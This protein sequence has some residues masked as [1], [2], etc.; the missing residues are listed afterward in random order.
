MQTLSKRQVGIFCLALILVLFSLAVPLRCVALA[1]LVGGVT[2]FAGACMGASLAMTTRT[3]RPFQIYLWLGAAFLTLA[4]LYLNFPGAD[5][6]DVLLWKGAPSIASNY[7]DV[8]R[9]GVFLLAIPYPFALLGHH[10]TDYREEER[11][12]EEDETTEM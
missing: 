6:N 10:A 9:M 11:A 1:M 3:L 12:N 4:P 7:F 2:G 8:L 5:E